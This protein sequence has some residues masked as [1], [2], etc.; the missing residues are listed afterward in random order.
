MYPIRPNAV[1]ASDFTYIPFKNSFIYLAT[2]L[3]IFSREIVDFSI[4]TDHS[5]DLVEE[6]FN[7]AK[8]R[9][10]ELPQIL[11]SDQ[12]SEYKSESYTK[13]LK[14]HGINI[15][16]SKKASPWEN[17]FQEAFYSGF[18]FDLGATNRFQDKAQLIEAICGTI[19]YYNK[20]RI[21][22]ALKMS[23]SDFK[24]RYQEKIDSITKTY[25]CSNCSIK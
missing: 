15:S 24:N 12:G 10:A 9:A 3:D 23:P 8:Q 11:H 13:L 7:H 14:K 18:K 19:N 6:A 21:H 17:S 4:R 5:T 1:W 22:S 16:M 20:E 2:I 25:Q